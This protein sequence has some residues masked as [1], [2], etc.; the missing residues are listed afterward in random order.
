MTRIADQHGDQD[1]A[2]DE[3]KDLFNEQE[4]VE[5]NWTIAAINA[6]NRMSVGMRT[7]PSDQ[8]LE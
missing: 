5:L 8:P 7:P 4:I 3:L 1:S 6:W 2:F